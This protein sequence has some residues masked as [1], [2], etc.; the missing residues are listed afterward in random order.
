MTLRE[1]KKKTTRLPLVF[2]GPGL[3]V[4]AVL[5]LVPTLFAICISLQDRELGQA[6]TGWVWFSNYIQ[7][8]SDRRFLNSVRVSL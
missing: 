7:L 3:L 8:F 1:K 4:L 5:A 2:I 6:D